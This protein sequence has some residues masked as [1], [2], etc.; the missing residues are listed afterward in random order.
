MIKNNKSAYSIIIIIV[1]I[2]FLI[3]LTTWVFR[4]I[5][6][7]LRDNRVLW[8]YIKSY[9]GAESAQELAL[10]D[11]KENWY[12]SDKSLDRFD[13]WIMDF[14]WFSIKNQKDVLISFKNDWKTNSILSK[15]LKPS[16]YNTIP[17]FYLDSV[18]LNSSWDYN[19]VSLKDYKIWIKNWMQW[20]ISWNIIWEKTWISW[21]WNNFFSGSS[22]EYKQWFWFIYN[23]NQTISQFLS[24]SK[25]NYLQLYNA[26]TSD[27]IYD[28]ESNWIFTKPELTIT[29]S[30]ESWKYRTNINTTISLS[31]LTSK[32]KY[33]I[34]SP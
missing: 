3:I 16:E 4:L 30:W 13:I 14:K 29:S 1:I 31:D 28:I 23:A 17:L 10:L 15:V 25:T 8:N 34:F 6:W 24:K 22:K 2:W 32:S 26:W 12:W 21:D 5:L 20:D 27:F 11:I 7:E 18:N 9:A 19:E 33:S